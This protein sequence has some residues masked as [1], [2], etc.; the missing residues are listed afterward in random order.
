MRMGRHAET[1][2]KKAHSR[3]EIEKGARTY[4]EKK[5]VITEVWKRRPA[6]R[7]DAL[8]HCALCI[9]RKEKFLEMVIQ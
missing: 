9:V 8:P 6:I 3:S 1:Y 7:K 2:W 5:C 4:C